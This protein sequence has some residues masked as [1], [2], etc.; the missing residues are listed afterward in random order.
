MCVMGCNTKGC[1]C[2]ESAND[3]EKD[4]F[5]RKPKKV[6]KGWG[7]ELHIH[8]DDGYCGKILHFYSGKKFSM[9]YHIKKKETW[10]CSKGS[11]LLKFINTEN[12]DV[13][14]VNLK[15]GDVVEIDIGLPHQLIALEESEI[16]EVSQPDDPKDSYRVWK[17]DSQ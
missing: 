11:F 9:H 8:N 3:L 10:F 17:G 15:M 7:Y 5:I 13:N 6:D 14:E 2:G 1:G 4:F 12:A 16:F